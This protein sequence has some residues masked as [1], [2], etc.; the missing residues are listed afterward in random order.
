MQKELDVA[1][2]VYTLYSTTQARSDP[3]PFMPRTAPK[4]QVIKTPTRSTPAR[5]AAPG[6]AASVRAAS[7]DAAAHPT[8]RIAESITT[9][10][11]ERRLMRGP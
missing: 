1:A 2:K 3:P 5:A 9:A 4:L 10:I 8:Q 6:R 11:V 7:S